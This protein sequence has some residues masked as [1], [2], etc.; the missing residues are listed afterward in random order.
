M[1]PPTGTPTQGTEGRIARLSVEEAKAAAESIGVPVFMADLSVFQVLLRHPKLAKALNDLLSTLLWNSSLDARLREL[2]IMRLGWATASDYEW[3]Q[4]WR[5]ARGAGITEEDLVAL[6]GDWRSHDGFT[7]ADRAVLAATD[8]TMT[9]GAISA[10]TWAECEAQIT[11]TEALIEVVI[12][13]GNWRMFSSLLR[14]LEVPLEEGVASW[15]PDGVAPAGP[16][17]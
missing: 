4:H 2:I 8:D 15:P 5:I 6:R 9:T 3:T 12:A 11:D 17:S 13:I 7:A 1:N 10:K 16:S 14:S